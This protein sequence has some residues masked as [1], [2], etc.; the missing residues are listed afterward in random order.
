MMVMP[1]LSVV[2]PF[3]N[4]Q[5]TLTRA[6]QSVANQTFGNFECILVNNNSTDSSIDIANEWVLRDKRFKLINEPGQG[7]AFASTAGSRQALG[8]FIARID[9]DD[10]A[11]PT[12]FGL[13]VN[14]LLQN[15]QCGVVGGL[16]EY[17]A[18]K[19]GTDGFKRYINW[20][21]SV[22]S[23]SDILKYRFVESP[24]VNP[25]AM[26]RKSIEQQ[27]G[28]YTQGNYPEDYELWLRWLHNGVVIDKIEKP[29]IKWYDSD[30]RLTRT[31]C[32]YA[33]KAFNYIKAVYANLL[34]K[35]INP[36][37]PKIAVWGAGKISRKAV[38]ELVQQGTE[39]DF[40]IDIHTKRQLNCNVVFYENIPS[41]TK[42][43]VVVYVNH[44]VY[45][46]Q[47]E[48]YLT[49]KGFVSGVNYLLM[50]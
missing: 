6:I 47:I 7:V 48:K 29:L 40:F 50:S 45:R 41:P 15:P 8:Q 2:L 42:V 23:Y 16:V 38:H 13:Q 5:N 44:H 36:H 18:H 46:K 32:Q 3:Y 21:N 33:V 49:Q 10:E 26:W 37:Y 14:H 17:V 31:N 34:L 20:V 24:I 27:Y 28:G 35:K 43:F 25:T 12:R 39:I 22:I 19:P 1:L 4:A 9:A 11:L 30:T